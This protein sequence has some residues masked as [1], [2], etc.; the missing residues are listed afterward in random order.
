[1]AGD[2][3]LI[4]P[5]LARGRLPPTFCLR[6]ATAAPS[7]HFQRLIDLPWSPITHPAEGR[8]RGMFNAC[9]YGVSSRNE[10]SSRW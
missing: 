5:A 1:M 9:R 2:R 10:C 4:N 3:W 6:D 8:T 7:N